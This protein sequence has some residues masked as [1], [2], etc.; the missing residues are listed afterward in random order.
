MKTP[1]LRT[2]LTAAYLSAMLASSVAPVFSNANLASAATEAPMVVMPVGVAYTKTA[3]PAA[4]PVMNEEL[5]RRLIIRA[6]A[7]RKDGTIEPAICAIFGLCQAGQSLPAKQIGLTVPEGKHIFSV[8]MTEGSNDVIVAFKREGITELYLTNRSGVLRAAGIADLSGVRLI[9][10]EQA[11][12]KYKYEMDFFANAAQSLPPSGT[13]V[14]R[15][16]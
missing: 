2:V 10:N 3:S 15:N 4:D 5:M 13:V 14:A 6:L 16:S 11:A 1:S 8:T 12:G 7:S 9:T